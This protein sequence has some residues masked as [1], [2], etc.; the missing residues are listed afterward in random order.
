MRRNGVRL[1]TFEFIPCSA[2]LPHQPLRFRAGARR[3]DIEVMSIIACGRRLMLS[4]KIR[5]KDIRYDGPALR[6]TDGED[7]E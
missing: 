3:C 1:I 5:Q 6:A 2:Y 4:A 7:Y